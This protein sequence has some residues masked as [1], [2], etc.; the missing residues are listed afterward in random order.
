MNLRFFP[1]LI[2]DFHFFFVY[3]TVLFGEYDCGG[4]GA[5]YTYRVS[6][7]KQLTQSVARPYMDVSYIDGEEWLLPRQQGLFTPDHNPTLI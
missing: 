5:N 2:V 3:R 1:F 7:G 4:S 6:Y